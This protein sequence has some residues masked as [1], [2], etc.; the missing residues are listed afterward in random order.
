MNIRSIPITFIALALL[1]ACASDKNRV[2]YAAKA[3][4]S[5]S[6]EVP[7]DLTIPQTTDRFAIPGRDEKVA[8]FSDYSK[9]GKEISK[10]P[11]KVLPANTLVSLERSG[12]QRWLLVSDKAE[13][14]WP[15]VKAFWVETGFA[16]SIDDAKAGVL[17]TDWQENISDGEG[18]SLGRLFSGWSS[19]GKRDQFLTRLERSKDGKSTEI[20]I[21][22]RGVQDASKNE[23]EGHQWMPRESDPELEN[24]ILQL[25]AIKLQNG[26][27]VASNVKPAPLP[28]QVATTSAVAAPQ[29]KDGNNSKVIVI[30]EA[31]DKAWRKVSL[32]LDRAR[33]KVEDK[34]R[35]K[36]I[37][38]LRVHPKEGDNLVSYQLVV[39]EKEG[40]SEVIVNNESGASDAVG[41][42][43][44]E[45]VFQQINK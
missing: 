32:A 17:E 21:S 15:K 37:F 11:A 12:T 44:L 2:D 33:I 18:S 23:K 40:V 13:S 16:L 42:R 27:A 25:L 24:A 26:D 39:N 19:S 4:T 30:N 20:Y 22:H 14:V 5:P 28:V 41:Q 38:Y 34:D 9:G 29:W 43:I 31:F 3:I 45:A 36:G 10:T 6:L 8:S 35:T 1:S 7:P